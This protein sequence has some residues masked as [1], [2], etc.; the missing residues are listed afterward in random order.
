MKKLFSILF[1]LFISVQINFA[2][3][4]DEVILKTLQ[5]IKTEVTNNNKIINNT[6]LLSDVNGPRVM[7]SPGFFKAVDVTLKKLAEIKLDNI[8]TEDW[9]PMGKSWEVKKVTALQTAPYFSNL[10]AFPKNWSPATKGVVKGKA[11]YFEARTEED[12]EKYKGKLK[13]A[14]VLVGNM[15][16]PRINYNPFVVRYTDAELKKLEETAPLTDEQKNAELQK[17]VETDKATMDALSINNKKIAFCMK[18]GALVAI[19]HGRSIYGSIQ[20]WAALL[21]KTATTMEEFIGATSNP[22]S[23]ATIPQLVVSLEQYNSLVRTIKNGVDVNLEINLETKEGAPVKGVNVV[24]EIP[25]TDLKNEIVM[26]G[27]HLDSQGPSI[28]ATDNA[29]G[30]SICIE[31]MRV[32]KELKI[33]PRRTIR[34]AIWGGEEQGFF[35]STAYRDK[36]FSGKADKEKLHMYFNTDFGAGRYRGLF[37]EERTDLVNKFKKWFSLINMN[38]ISCIT[39]SENTDHVPFA[40]KGMAA[41]QFIQDPLDYLRFFHTNV[42]RLERIPADDVRDNAIIMASLAFLAAME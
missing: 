3:I 20:A 6:S 15:A 26:I 32:L 10:I 37:L 29:V 5:D 4:S 28:G 35:G 13:G 36:H 1:L 25:G 34:I 18:E 27:G 11:V 24:A 9:T 19:D 30:V 7:W 39:K 2:Q 40:E 33:Q 12:F 38:L 42:D 23:G 16:S 8:H 21:P 14:I 17:K 31:A 41:F 22:N